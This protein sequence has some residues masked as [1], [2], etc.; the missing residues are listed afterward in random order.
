MPPVRHV[1]I[2]GLSI[3]SSGGY[4]VGR[5]LLRHLAVARPDWQF[6]LALVGGY[7]LH[8]AMRQEALPANGEILWAPPATLGRL[9]RR[10][11]E[12]RDLVQWAEGNR[13]DAV[14]QL[15]G[16]V[17]PEMRAPTLAHQQDPWPYR[18]EAWASPTDR[19]FALVKRRA[20][21]AAL[22]RA[23][24]VG[25]TSAYLRD[26]ICNFHQIRPPRAAVFYNGVPDDWVER[27]ASHAGDAPP[28]ATRPMELVSV[29]NINAFKR[30]NLVIKAL[31]VLPRMPA[32]A[33]L[34]YRIIGHGPPAY[35]KRLQQLAAGL[36]V[37]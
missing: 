25:F 32:M 16:M 30:Q 26:L 27:A 5:E 18:P 34:T 22:R 21:R 3:G 19:I 4:T 33:E 36:G 11:Y 7:H 14:I 23:A 10:R 28:W 1:L 35:I 24:Y 13:I 17:I 2:N 37:G 6:T 12:S 9:A 31:P 29:S 15:N 8:E 20:H